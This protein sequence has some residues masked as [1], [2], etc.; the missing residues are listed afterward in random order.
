ENA[1]ELPLLYREREIADRHQ[2]LPVG[3]GEFLG[4]VL[5]AEDGRH[6]GSTSRYGGDA[7][8]EGAAIPPVRRPRRRAAPSPRY[9]PSRP[10]PAQGC[11][12]PWQTRSAP[13][14]RSAPPPSRPRSRRTT[15]WPA[16][17]SAPK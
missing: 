9:R 2:P 7:P 13:R 4:D 15:K 1:N 16:S 10:A 12:N 14:A 5:S 3:N 11:P 6:D 8:T 17:P